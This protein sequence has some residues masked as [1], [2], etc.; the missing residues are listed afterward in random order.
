MELTFIGAIQV[1][2][3]LAIVFVGS[4]RSAL[5]FVMMSCLLNGS[6]AIKLTAIGGS[7]ISPMQ[8]ALVF[9]LL[10]ALWPGS[11]YMQAIPEVIRTNKWLF[12][13]T[14]F[15]VIISYAGPRIFAGAIDVTP[16]RPLLTSD[17][18]ATTPLE[19]TTQNLTATLYIVGAF[20]LTVISYLVCRQR[21]GA[22]TVVSGLV[23]MG[24]LHVFLGILG[25]LAFGTPLDAFLDLFRNNSYAQLG[26][27]YGN[28]V[29]IRGLSPE[30]S[31]Y[32]AFG[33]CLFVANCELWF[34]LVRPTA[35]GTVA[36]ALATILFFSTSSTAYVALLTYGLIV[37]IRSFLVPDLLTTYHVKAIAKT[38]GLLIFLTAIIFAVVPG[39]PAQVWDMIRHM[40]VDKSDSS[41]GQQR[42]FWAMQ[43]WEAFKASYG[44][45]I[46]P[47]SFRSSSMASALMGSTGII[48]IVTFCTYLVMVLK[49]WRRS[50][51][52]YGRD[53][54]NMLGGAFAAAA[55]FTLIPGTVSASHMEPLEPFAVLAGA[56]LAVRR[57]VKRKAPDMRRVDPRVLPAEMAE[58]PAHA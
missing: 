10:R 7:S 57:S 54:T 19:P 23:W 36:L 18:F 29:R 37:I 13:F 11:G 41:S 43:G 45:G 8:L 24:A 16:L 20:L 3:G 44:L 35:T 4:L 31:T 15:A 12:F 40:T 5:F 52:G 51:W 58:P 39:A 1:I 2:V 25:V 42:L 30:A 27:E 6:A 9:A 14:L 17:L 49:P 56:S 22:A 28:F 38:L 53:S 50:S 21:G 55:F 48:G 26:L 33:F 47:G 46:G 34:R 32:A